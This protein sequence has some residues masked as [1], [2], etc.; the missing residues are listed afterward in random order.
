M[1]SGVVVAVGILVLFFVAGV[2][3]VGA[4]V[5]VSPEAHDIV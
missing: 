3:G 5:E 4:G 1:N 2:V